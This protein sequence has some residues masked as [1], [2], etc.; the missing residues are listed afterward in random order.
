[1]SGPTSPRPPG[2]LAGL[3]HAS[4]NWGRP[5]RSGVL[6]FGWRVSLILACVSAGAAFRGPR[7]GGPFGA[8]CRFW[9]LW[10]FVAA[11]WPG[12]QCGYG[13]FR[14]LGVSALWA[15]WSRASSRKPTGDSKRARTAAVSLSYSRSRNQWLDGSIWKALFDEQMQLQNS[16]TLYQN[17]FFR[18]SV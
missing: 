6:D 13:R 3:A 4:C 10:C 11:W 14:F 9:F 8:G 5:G 17:S 16:I 1:M 12:A 2:R 18:R 15:S 7:A